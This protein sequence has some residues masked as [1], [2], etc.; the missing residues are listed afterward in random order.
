MDI[1]AVELEYCFYELVYILYLGVLSSWLTK[2]CWFSTPKKTINR[3]SFTELNKECETLPRNKIKKCNSY[4]TEYS[5]LEAR[6]KT[7]TEEVFVKF[8]LRYWKD[9]IAQ[10]RIPSV[11]FLFEFSCDSS[12]IYCSI[13]LW[14]Y[15]CW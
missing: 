8:F 1:F 14:S 6:M 11:S 13:R 5:M 7:F 9:T 10:V 12:F 4:S 15:G 3:F 2:E